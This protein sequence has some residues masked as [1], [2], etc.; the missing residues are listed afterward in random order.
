MD[1]SADQAQSTS[2]TAAPTS[3]GPTE[4]VTPAT[5]PAWYKDAIIYQLHVRAFCD[6]NGDGVGDFPGLIQKLDYLADLGVTTLWLLPFY[7]SPLKDDGYDIAD[8]VNVNPAYGTLDDFRRFVAEAHQRGMRI[9]T[10]LVINHTSDQHAWFQAA[11]KAPPGSPER[12]FYVWSDTDQKYKDARIIF[13]D[14]EPSNWTWDRTA[15]AY[16]WHRFFSHQPDLNFDNPKVTEAMIEVMKFWLDMGVDGM[17]LDAIPYLIERDG[18]NCENLPETHVVLKTIR[19]AMDDHYPDRMFLAEAN[20]WPSDVRAYFG[21]GDECHMAFHFPLMPRMFMALRQEDRHPIT[22]IL[23]QT[24]D[25]PENCQ[26]A[27]FLRNH[28]EL[29]LEMVTDEERDYMYREYASDPR[30]R[31]NVG[32]RRRLAPLLD[33]SPRRI[34][35]LNSLL[36]SLPGTPVIY[37]GDEIGMGDNIYLGDRNGVRT[38]MQWNADRNAGFS[39]ADFSRLYSPP[40]M[41]PINNYQAVNVEA[42]K[43]SPSSLLNWMKRLISL[44]KRHPT[45]GRGSLRFLHPRN[46]K[47]LAYLRAYGDETILCVANM[48]RFVQPVELDLS[49]F[50]HSVPVEMLGGV[51]F[52]E[53][54]ELPYFLTL[55]PHSFLWFRLKKE[56]TSF[57]SGDDASSELPRLPTVT[58][59]T[60]EAVLQGTARKTLLREILPAYLMRQRWFAG[61]AKEIQSIDIKDA[62]RLPSETLT[63]LLTVLEVHYRDGATELYSLPIGV[64]SASEAER[65]RTAVSTSLIAKL[66]LPQGEALLFDALADDGICQTLLQW[67][68]AGQKLPTR[69]GSLIPE[70]TAAYPEIRGS[71]DVPIRISRAAP[72]QSNSFVLFLPQIIFKLYRKL[73]AGVNP[74]YEIG[75]YLTESVKF[76]RIPRMGGAIEYQDGTG[77]HVMAMLQQLVHNQGN[78]W[79]HALESLHRYFERV[80]VLPADAVPASVAPR[81]LFDATPFELPPELQDTLG[82]Y[83]RSAERLGQRTA[84]LHLALASDTQ[85]SEFKPESLR[86]ADLAAQITSSKRDVKQVFQVLSHHAD[87]LDDAIAENAH[88]LLGQRSNLN[89]RLDEILARDPGVTK[90]RVHGDYHLGQVLW[91]EN[92]YVILDFEGEP[93]RA[94]EERRLKQSPLKDVAGMLRSFDYAAYAGLFDATRDRPLDLERLEPWARLWQSWISAAFL[95]SYLTTAKGAAFIPNDPRDLNALLRFYLLQKAVYE[96]L[97]ELNN[98]P[99]WVRIPLHGILGLLES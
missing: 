73:E 35:L 84:E 70:T 58:I 22:D 89:R 92:D 25:I 53:I 51:S 16:F 52:P 78:G 15:N 17:R 94:L 55:G 71:A 27:I 98:R 97:Y 6:S 3:S 28:D 13:T 81:S 56:S 63:C 46:R 85:L 39:S 19:K 30:M 54:G 57:A 34:E 20:Q 26:W 91:A 69:L 1:Q 9:I 44:R 75:R 11:R 32:I 31:I 10:E 76:P 86:M 82:D 80:V 93:A 4:S 37:Y 18:T 36:M 62:T 79:T 66:D 50:K 23:R 60:W 47:V 72:H 24:P 48:S 8:Y 64:A 96:L 41:D 38:P 67:V 83:I 45:F 12:D 74:D 61:K 77:V 21:D 43:R 40:L 42:Q 87:R 14:T 68:E 65:L 2:K 33:H 29:T 7:P 88:R 99:D 49:E 90:I 5:Q 59:A 95:N